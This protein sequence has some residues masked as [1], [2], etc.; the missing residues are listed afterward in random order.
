MANYRRGRGCSKRRNHQFS[1]RIMRRRRE[2]SD[3]KQDSMR[4]CKR[5]YGEGVA[6]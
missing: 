5:N 2:Q 3:V 6:R 1:R 4:D